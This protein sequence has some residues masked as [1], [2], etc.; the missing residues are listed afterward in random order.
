M[1]FWRANASLGMTHDN[2]NWDHVTEAAKLGNPQHFPLLHLYTLLISQ[3]IVHTDTPRELPTRRH[4][5]M[6]FVVEKCCR[7]IGGNWNGKPSSE[8]KDLLIVFFQELKRHQVENGK[9]SLRGHAGEEHVVTGLWGIAAW[10]R[11]T[12]L[13]VKRSPEASPERARSTTG[14][15][16][17]GED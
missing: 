11:G 16:D 7:K 12:A 15:S 10:R 4:E 17:C 8:F 5:I 2:I 14:W 3:S 1:L 13:L 9:L 6:N